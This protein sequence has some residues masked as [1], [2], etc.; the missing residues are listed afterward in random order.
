MVGTSGRF[1]NFPGFGRLLRPIL[2]AFLNKP[3][4]VVTD[5]TPLRALT[6]SVTQSPVAAT[7]AQLLDGPQSSVIGEATKRAFK[8]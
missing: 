5:N 7:D 6:L 4:I 3:A 1:S 2:R 8:I